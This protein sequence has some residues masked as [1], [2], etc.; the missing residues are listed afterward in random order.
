MGARDGYEVRREREAE[1]QREQ[2]RRGREIGPLP[3]VVDPARK[4]AAAADPMVFGEV[5]FPHR[6][7]L[8]WSADHRQVWA[9]A[10]E[11]VQRGGLFALAMARGSGK[12]SIFEV[13]GMW[14]GM[15]GQQNGAFSLLLG[16]SRAH[17]LNMMDAIKSELEH[18]DLLAED[19][20]EVC[21]PIRCLEGIANRCKG[22]LLDGRPTEIGWRK[23]QIVL[24]TVDG[25]QASGCII[26]VA[27]ITASI[28]GAKH[29]RPDGRSVRPSLVLGDD[30][31]TDA[32][33]R[34]L[35]QCD[36]RERILSGAVLGLAGPGQPIAVLC[37]CT[38]IRKGD[39][40]DNLLD[41]QKHPE[42]TGQ[43]FRLV[44]SYPQKMD[45]WDQYAV[46][47]ADE[48]RNGGDGSQATEFYRSNR[49]LMDQGAVVGWPER[50]LPDELSAIQ[51]AMNRYYRDRRAH[52]AED[53]NDPQE[54]QLSD[55]PQLDAAAIAARTNG[56]GRGIVPSWA[57]RLTAFCDVQERL[58]YW[59]VC[60]WDDAFR[61]AIV[62]Y[63][64][65]P[66][67]GRRY[68][69]LR[70][71]QRTLGRAAP[72]AGME[73]ALHAGLTR[74]AE[75]LLAPEW[76]RDGG[77]GVRIERL[78]VDANW[79][80]STATIYGWCRGSPH[81]ALLVP[82]HGR[83]VGASS[84]PWHEYQKKEG[85]R[86]GLHWEIPPMSGKRGDVRHLNTDTNFW[87]TFVAER[88]TAAVGDK[89]AMVLWG[90][91]GEDHRLLADH[92]T[93][94][95]RVR[96]EGRGRVVD[97]WKQR[98]DRPDNHWFDGLVGCAALAS[99]LGC[100][101]AGTEDARRPAKRVSYAEQYR[102]AKAR[103]VS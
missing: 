57:T 33:A 72:G 62:D 71:A 8:A 67:Q 94:E 82:C 48:L 81:S 13:V 75:L 18:N 15:S 56:L 93:A 55:L 11:A 47:R 86:L 27:G 90:K 78:G 39:L 53:Q 19:W 76:R 45:L 77:G 16:P 51:H 88:L 35:T 4:A 60:A 32:S 89:G 85:G 31:Q 38:V 99:V 73:G 98:P 101:L 46:R 9:R 95:Y 25:S 26:R 20:P 92:L 42:W 12:T 66:D 69:S 49:E 10:K 24:P 40:A 96:T 41:R 37:A 103:K 23:D 100:T 28:R 21:Y 84:K 97:E 79:G 17:A 87:K 7:T 2:A 36:Q 44:Y 1:R 43:R 54:D 64:T 63:G 30:P 61:G 83:Y 34:S 5:Y 59:L 74:L 3:A 102:Q 14:A 70:D 91:A 22:Q 29:V 68:F 50:F 80:Q 58:L 6:F 52:A 65:Y